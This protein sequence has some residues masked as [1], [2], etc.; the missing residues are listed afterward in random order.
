MLEE[1]AT[2]LPSLPTATWVDETLCAARAQQRVVAIRFGRTADPLCERCDAMLRKVVDTLKMEHMLSV[3]TVDIDEVPEFTFMY[4]LYDPFTLM[5]FHS[6][7]PIIVNAGY[8]PSRKV[9]EL[10][11]PHCSPSLSVLLSTAARA[12]LNDMPPAQYSVPHGIQSDSRIGGDQPDDAATWSEEASR[13]AGVARSWLSSKTAPALERAMPLLKQAEDSARGSVQQASERGA[14]AFETA[15][16]SVLR[17]INDTLG[18]E[19]WHT[20]PPSPEARP[21]SAGGGDHASYSARPKWTP[22]SAP[23]ACPAEAG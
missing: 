22:A 15:R 5:L 3:Y 16:F 23:A 19:A 20:P 14:A 1:E 17:K 4:E 2:K 10:P 8:G 11:T 18:A 7:K 21:S 12:T 13:L 9:T 6:S